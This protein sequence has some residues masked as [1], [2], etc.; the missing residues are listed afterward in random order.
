MT[1]GSQVV[2]LRGLDV[3]DDGDEIGGVAQVT[4]VQEDLDSGLVAVLVDV[5]N[6]ASIEGT[7][8]TYDA[9]DLQQENA[10]SSSDSQLDDSIRRR[11]F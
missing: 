8:A 5:L 4:V 10:V 7:G 6:S 9:V 3:I 2:D 1:H 11:H